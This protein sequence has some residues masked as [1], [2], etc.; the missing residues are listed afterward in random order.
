MRLDQMLGAPEAPVGSDVVHL[1]GDVNPTN[2]DVSGGSAPATSEIPGQMTV[3]ECVAEAEKP[4]FE[5]TTTPSGQEI[6]YQWA[7]KR[8]YRMGPLGGDW[9][10]HGDQGWVEVPSVT[11]VLGV[12]EKPA[13]VWWGM[14]VGVSGM[15]ELARQGEVDLTANMLRHHTADTAAELADEFVDLLTEHRLTVNHVKDKAADRGINVH[16]ALESWCK[17]GVLPIVEQYPEAERGYIDGLCAF[18]TAIRNVA[19]VDGME[20]MVGSLEHLYAGRFDLVLNISQPVEMV[21]K[22]YPKR[23]DKMQE[24]S[25]GR[26][27]L[28]LK[29]SKRV[30]P[31]HFLQ[32]EA[33]E[34]ASIECGY[35]PTDHRGVVHATADGKYELALNTEWQFEDFLAVR[36]VYTVMNERE[37]LAAEREIE[38]A[39]RTELGAKDVA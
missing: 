14:K 34:K 7:P 39:L 10:A 12:L 27:L 33:Y 22:C 26:Y 3:E 32:L 36:N 24:I 19:E 17:H 30:Y 37:K 4:Q 25:A 6:Y 15:V 9:L 16:D 18:L 35:A 2:G 20:V 11:T 21:T 38:S 31:T 1:V 8:L 5:Q 23:A 13:L 28:D 29:T